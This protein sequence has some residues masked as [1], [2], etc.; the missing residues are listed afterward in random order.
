MVEYV[1]WYSL[2][3]I[4]FISFMIFVVPLFC[5]FNSK[6]VQELRRKGYRL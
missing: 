4:A 1:M 3:C 2:F 5:V 6:R